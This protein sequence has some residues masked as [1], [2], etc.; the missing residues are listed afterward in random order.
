QF[1]FGLGL[2]LALWV[3]GRQVIRGDLA[4]GDLAKAVFYLMAI[5][6]RVGMVGQFTNIIQNASASAERILEI[7][8]EPQVIKGGKLDLPG[9]ALATDPPLTPSALELSSAAGRHLSSP[10]P[11]EARTGRGL[12]RGVS[13]LGKQPS[14]T[15]PSP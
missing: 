2:P 4:I 10:S 5:G 11:R 1:I 13:E 7:I 14:S 8:H 6:H 3:G 15:R 9:L 12:G